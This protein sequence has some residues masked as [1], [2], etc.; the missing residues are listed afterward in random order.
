MKP[1]LKMILLPLVFLIVAGNVAGA[2]I[3]VYSDADLW[4]AAVAAVPGSTTSTEMLDDAMLAPWLSIMSDLPGSV[5]GGRWLSAVDSSAGQVDTFSLTTPMLVF[6]FGGVFDL[7]GP[8]GSGEGIELSASFAGMG[9]TLIDILPSDAAEFWGF[10]VSGDSFDMVQLRG[11]GLAAGPE[12]YSVDD[13]TIG[14]LAESSPVP[15]PASFVLLGIAL[16]GLALFRR[17]K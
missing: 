9:S 16:V 11:A 10:I 6:A 5:T 15:E 17:R 14:H 2:T 12:M 8:G 7:A 1:I 3:T 4:G 13:L